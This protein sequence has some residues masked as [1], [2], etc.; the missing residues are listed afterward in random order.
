LF[1]SKIGLRPDSVSPVRAAV[2]PATPEMPA[3]LVLLA[4]P[5]SEPRPTPESPA[6]RLLHGA[7]VPAPKPTLTLLAS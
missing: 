4:L 6:L 5:L 2:L 3:V 1:L 7:G